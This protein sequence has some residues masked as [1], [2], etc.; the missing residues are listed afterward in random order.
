MYKSAVQSFI[1]LSI[2]QSEQCESVPEEKCTTVQEE[3][4]EDVEEEDCSVT[5]YFLVFFK[6]FEQCTT[7]TNVQW[8]QYI[9]LIKSWERNCIVLQ[10]GETVCDTVDTE[11]CFTKYEEEC[12]T[13]YK[14][15][16]STEYELV[17][18]TGTIIH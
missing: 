4:C 11:E 17:C 12:E 14:E 13:V 7:L 8:Y 6:N 9:H 10:E 5:I 15:R 2:F 18:T 1:Y 16:C 3:E